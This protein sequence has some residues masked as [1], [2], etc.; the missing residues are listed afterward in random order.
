MKK[1]VGQLKCPICHDIVYLR[2]KVVLEKANGIVHRT[3]YF[4]NVY[5]VEIK[6]EG[7]FIELIKKYSFLR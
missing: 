4:K 7:R 6:D 5:P 1:V 3:C 2:E